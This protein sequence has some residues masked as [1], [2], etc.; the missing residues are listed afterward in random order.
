MFEGFEGVF[1]LFYK[2]SGNLVMLDLL[3]AFQTF[4]RL[5]GYY[6]SFWR[7]PGIFFFIILGVR[8]YYDHFGRLGVFYSFEGIEEYFGHVRGS[9][10]FN[11]F[12]AFKA[13]WVILEVLKGI[14]IILE[15]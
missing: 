9:E 2:F 3:G 4:S 1:W 11:H 5:W 6:F 14:L 8:E 12:G 7:I 13:F 15:I 10:Y